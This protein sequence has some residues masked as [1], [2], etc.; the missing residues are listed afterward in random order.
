[1]LFAP[2]ISSLTSWNSHQGI[3]AEDALFQLEMNEFML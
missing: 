3:F 2:P 1:V